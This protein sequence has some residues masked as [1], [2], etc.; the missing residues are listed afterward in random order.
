MQCIFRAFV[1][2]FVLSTTPE[3]HPKG[4]AILEIYN[5]SDLE[6]NYLPLFLMKIQ[7]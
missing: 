3:E 6:K 7:L 5:L 4:G 1:P 2:P